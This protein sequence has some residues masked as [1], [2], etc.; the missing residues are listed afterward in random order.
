MKNVFYID[1]AD[2]HFFSDLTPF[3]FLLK[4]SQKHQLKLSC[5]NVLYTFIS[6]YKLSE[7]ETKK[8]CLLLRNLWRLNIKG[9]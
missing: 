9:C 5:L 7:T 3:N 6:L 2:F 4:L 8:F 1:A